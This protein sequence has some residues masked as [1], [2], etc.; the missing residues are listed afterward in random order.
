VR[1]DGDDRR[2]VGHER[3]VEQRLARGGGAADDVG[4]GD[5]V[6]DARAVTADHVNVLDGAHR[7]DGLDVTVGLRAAAEDEQPARVGRGECAHRERRDRRRAHVGQRD[8]VDEGDGRERGRV[9]DDA[10]ALDARLAAD[11]HE[12]DHRV[13]RRRGR[14]HEQLTRADRQRAAR[15][16][17][18]WVE[19]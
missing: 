4:A 9:E 19:A 13:G 3:A 10:D 2:A 17:G 1:A 5:Q 14:H 6:P 18:L 12:L 11:G 15:R 16:V 7:A 8:P